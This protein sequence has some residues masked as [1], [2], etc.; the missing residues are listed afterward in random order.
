M[1]APVLDARVG[2]FERGELDI[3]VFVGDAL[4][5]AA[6]GGEG[7]DGFGADEVGDFEGEGDVF[8]G[9]GGGACD[10]LINMS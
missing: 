3:G 1:R 10:L 5:Q 6:G 9:G 8:E 2:E 7:G 4:A